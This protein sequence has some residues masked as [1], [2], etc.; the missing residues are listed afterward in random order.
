MIVSIDSHF[1]YWI[2]NSSDWIEVNIIKFAYIRM[3]KNLKFESFSVTFSNQKSEKWE[4][5][6]VKAT[7]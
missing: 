1:W 7:F 2:W 6:K 4:H 5:F 3:S